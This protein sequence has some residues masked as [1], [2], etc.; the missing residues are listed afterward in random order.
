VSVRSRMRAT[1]ALCALPLGFAAGHAFA[2]VEDG[3]AAAAQEVRRTGCGERHGIAA[4]LRRDPQLD[5]V[6]AAWSRG[7]SLAAALERIGVRARRSASLQVTAQRPSAQIRQSLRAGLCTALTTADYASLGVY[8][9][10]SQAW[11]IVAQRFITPPATAAAE[12]AARSLQLV[13]R[14]RSQA[15]RCGAR[16]YAAVDSLGTSA[17]L[18]AAALTQA[19]DLAAHSV[20]SHSGSDGSDPG[21]RATRSGYRWRVVGENVASGPQTAEEAVAGWLASPDHCENIMDPRYRE[22]GIAFAVNPRSSGVIYWSQVFGLP[23]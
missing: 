10:G 16:Q 4:A 21:A 14:A 7:G 1:V 9:K 8:T 13:N 23:R 2:D 12:I 6:A 20:L 22:M 19:R 15:R 11:I 3:V 17:Q 5:R 18:D